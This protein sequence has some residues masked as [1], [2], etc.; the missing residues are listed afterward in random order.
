MITNL[1]TLQMFMRAKVQ[2]MQ[3]YISW[4]CSHHRQW[5]IPTNW[6]IALEVKWFLA[7]AIAQL[8]DSGTR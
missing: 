1:V 4:L 3:K 7:A 6:F 2:Q 5:Y 8:Y